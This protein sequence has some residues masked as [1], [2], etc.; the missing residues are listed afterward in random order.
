MENKW[1][2]VTDEE[3]G[4]RIRWKV[5]KRGRWKLLKRVGVG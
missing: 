1:K 5:K 3:S 2:M 4:S